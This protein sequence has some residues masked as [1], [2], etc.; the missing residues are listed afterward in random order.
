[1]KQRLAIAL[2]LL[3]H[4]GWLLLHELAN[5]LDPADIMELREL[6]KTR[7]K[8]QGITVLISSHWPGKVGKM[9]NHV[10]ILFK[11]KRML[12]APLSGLQSFQQIA[13]SVCIQTSDNETAFSLLQ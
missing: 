2:A 10:G 3:P 11:G 7:N 9:V 1:M 4:P 12:R 5:G 6:I 8:T 13:A